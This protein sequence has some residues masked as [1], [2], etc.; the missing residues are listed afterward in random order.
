[1]KRYRWLITFFPPI[2]LFSSMAWTQEPIRLDFSRSTAE[3]NGVT[4]TGAG[5]GTVPVAVVT[6]GNIPTDNTFNGATDGRGA[7][8]QAD[9]GEGVMINPSVITT[10]NAV[11]IRCS[12]RADGPCASVVL[13]SI[14]QGNNNF[15][16]TITPANGAFFQDKYRRIA[17]FFIPPSHSFQPIIQIVNTS[18][19]NS[20]TVYLDNFEIIDLG[21]DRIDVSIEEIVGGP[22]GRE[23]TPDPLPTS[24]IPPISNS[25]WIE[26]TINGHF[27]STTDAMFW[28]QAENLA[29]SYGGHLV[30]INDEIENQWIVDNIIPIVVDG[31]CWIGYTDHDVEGN[32]VWISGEQ[33]SYTNWNQ[34]EPSNYEYED[35][36]AIRNN[37]FFPQMHGEKGE[38]G[39]FRDSTL[40]GIIETNSKPIIPTSTN[41]P[42]QTPTPTIN[43]TPTPTN[44]P[45]P[46]D[47]DVEFII[48]NLPEL[49]T[50]AKPLELVRI[51]AGTFTMGAPMDERGRYKRDWPPH[52]VTLTR[53]FFIGKY[54]ITQ[55]QWL[56]VMVKNPSSF[57]NLSNHPVEAVSWNNCQEFISKLN[58]MNQGTFRL[59]TEAE[60]EYAGRA[61]TI[62]R[63]SHGDVL[64]SGDGS[65]SS[66]IHDRYMWW[67]G[68]AK[69]QT[70]EVGLK[71]PNPWGLYD[72]HGSVCE[73]CSDWFEN[74][75]QRSDTVDPQGKTLGSYKVL[76]GGG[77]DYL[78][79]DCRSAIRHAYNP[80][81]KFNSVGIRVCRTLSTNIS[82]TPTPTVTDIQIPVP[83]ATL[84]PD[85]GGGNDDTITVNLPDLPLEA[86]PLELVR[87]KAGTFLMGSPTTEKYRSPAEQQHQVTL[88]KD[89]FIGKYEVTQAQWQY[90][91]GNNP[92]NFLGKPNNPV[93]NISWNDCQEFIS[94][95]N[96]M[97]Q[98]TFRLPTEAE[99]EYACRAGTTTRFFWGEDL[100][101]SQI[102]E[103]AWYWGNNYPGGTKEVGTTL[104][105]PWGLFD[106]SGN[107]REWCQDSFGDYPSIPVV[108][109]MD[110]NSG[111]ARVLRGG[112]WENI[113][114]VCRS[115]NRSGNYP[116]IGNH[117]D[118][119]R[120]CRNP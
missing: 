87:I 79:R 22:I 36:A 106:M 43:T 67:C 71:L 42:I 74:P 88:T 66:E 72:M 98:G 38:W 108:D 14:E 26:N 46:R 51:K 68:N 21:P 13:A 39:D 9:P 19:T 99:W 29:N 119:F 81:V 95:L 82:D 24:T 104:P 53:D 47:S 61:E 40:T 86:V 17:D 11:L 1:M 96:Q 65:E 78:A 5:F 35:F 91:M 73:W 15:V 101:Y 92:S 52:Q 45:T 49:P 20:L 75:Y 76:R 85:L 120:V 54:E 64:E 80:D 41:T 100:Y 116:N 6:F 90:V 2:F 84:T 89:F 117:V 59:P 57:K 30:T 83:S 27:Y 60:W 28:E 111:I 16:S 34:G 118:G 18:E 4:I 31:D 94:K 107:I 55:A 93:D 25:G 69:S 32:W 103:Y 3:E 12:V 7:I 97:S 33:S 115:A 62:T 44:T 56:A 112:C 63:Y 105:N 23:P 114:W 50:D 10:Q 77:W 109:P 37:S 102:K 48:V 8:I 58:Q 110:S 70:H 113:S